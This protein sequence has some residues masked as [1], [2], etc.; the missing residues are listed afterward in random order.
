MVTDVHGRHLRYFVAV[1]SRLALAC[2]EAFL[3]QGRQS[4]DGGT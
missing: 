1:P 2:A 3:G 4:T